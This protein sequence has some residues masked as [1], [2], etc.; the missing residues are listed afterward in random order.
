MFDKYFRFVYDFVKNNRR[1]ILYLI[2]ILNIAAAVGLCFVE[3]D[4]NVEVM[5]PESK[6]ISQSFQ[7]LRNSKL[8]NK[9]VISL[10]LTSPEKNKKDLALVVD[11]LA[12]SLKPPLFSEVTTGIDAFGIMRTAGFF[13]DNIPQIVS[14][15]DLS[16]IDSKINA[17]GISKNVHNIYRQM[18]KPGGFF[19]NSMV[20]SD[21]LFLKLIVFDK[22]KALSG[23]TEYNI[24]MEDGHFISKDGKHAMILAQTSVSAT[25]IFGAKKLFKY[26]DKQ[27]KQLP[28]YVSAKIISGHSHTLSNEKIMRKDIF[29]CSLITSIAFLV[30]FI[31]ILKDVSAVLV[32]LVPLS[33]ILI[34]V[35]LS[36]LV[37]GKISYMVI[38]LGTVLAGISVDHA[39]HVYISV[40]KCE[41]TFASIRNVCL[42][43]FAGAITTIAIFIAFYFSNIAGYHQLAFFSISGVVLALIYSLFLLPH[44]L[45]SKK[46]V[47]K[48]TYTQK[49][50][51]SKKSGRLIL[52][53]YAFMTII[54]IGFSFTVKFD[55]AINKIDG[56]E[57]EILKGEEAFRNIWGYKKRA[58]FV[59]TGK[60][61]EEALELNSKI[62]REAVKAIGV[63]N[64]LSLSSLW[65]SKKTRKKNAAR[66][67]EFWM[68]GREKKLKE[69]LSKE[70]E[71]Y[72]FSKDAFSPFFNNLY[73]QK[74]ATLENSNPDNK[75]LSMLIERFVQKQ[76]DG[77]KILSSFPDKRDYV[78]KI[79]SMTRRYPGTFLVS[80][81]AISDLIS[82]GLYKNIKIMIPISVILLTLLT[83]FC[84]GNIKE[85]I[86]SLVP[87]IT[88]IIWL[89]GLMPILGLTLNMANLITCLLILGLC[90]DYG[91]FMTYKHRSSL[92][93]GT[94]TAVAMAAV[95]TISGAGALI[96]AKHPALLSVGI[97][98]VIGV[99]TG[100][101]SSVLIVPQLTEI[102]L[103]K[104]EKTL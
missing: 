54:L 56:T 51:F 23:K 62:Y 94:N 38:G 39:I 60:S 75:F 85:T 70:G 71:K 8:S 11:K 64:F 69:L 55:N 49:K 100:Y 43:V 66:W 61:Y 86:I 88:S 74:E 82:D 9:I 28:P 44:Y 92:D 97:T 31:V 87:V 27:F 22:L 37:L 21:P 73:K 41:D 45:S 58:I 15:D 13:L 57:A 40:K 99:T 14:S 35:N 16:R 63:D 76:Q 32:F 96:F 6:Q 20:S 12:L 42:P 4:N 59:T 17:A 36:Y 90:V 93:I 1:I 24:D 84:M 81:I 68:D 5:L 2:I 29:L 95:T 102:F 3:Y 34:S 77:Y 104:N 30:L 103:P 83:Y 72:N 53:I 91:I 52:I 67:K 33:A 19:I 98:M 89:L 48:T 26:L 18:L 7:F 79:L 10:S 78:E 80:E 25:D 46:L 65:P 47:F 101:L 50:L